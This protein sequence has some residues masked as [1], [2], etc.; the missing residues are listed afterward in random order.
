MG[1]RRSTAPMA[2]DKRWDV[3][4]C[5]ASEDKQTLV[6]PVA[7]A[8]QRLGVK[9]WY[10]AF[11]LKPGDSLRRKVDEGIRDSRFGVVVLSTAFLQKN[12]PQHELDG[13]VSGDIAGFSG[14]IPIWFRVGKAT[15]YGYSP[16]LADKKAILVRGTPDPVR[17]AMEIVDAV[18]PDISEGIHRRAEFDQAVASAP[19]KMVASSSL[20]IPPIRHAGLSAPLVMRIRFLRAVL[21]STNPHSLDY[22][23]DGFR[24]DTHPEDEVQ[25]WER[26]ATNWVEFCTERRPSGAR[27]GNGYRFMYSLLQGVLLPATNDD[28][29]FILESWMSDH[30]LGDIEE[31]FPPDITEENGEVY[32]AIVQQDGTSKI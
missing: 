9:V 17:V 26:F 11:T 10:D 27:V 21:W 29:R 16:T 1:Q 7:R 23:I 3:F 15:V 13:L 30:P 31:T 2:I 6:D 20:S 32:A 8:L 22:W 19:R 5:H 28:E 14:I 4:V 24:R 25:R 12:W 18:R